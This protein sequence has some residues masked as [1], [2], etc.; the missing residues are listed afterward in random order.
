M[1]SLVIWK[2]EW[3]ISG[4]GSIAL[5]T[6]WPFIIRKKSYGQIRMTWFWSKKSEKNVQKRTVRFSA[7]LAA[8][9]I[10]NQKSPDFFKHGPDFFK[11]GPDFFKHGPDFFKLGPDFF[12]LGPDF[13][14]LGP[15]FFKLG[16]DFFKQ[17]VRIIFKPKVRILVPD[18][19][20]IL[21][22]S[23][24]KEKS[25]LVMVRKFEFFLRTPS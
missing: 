2:L 10:L 20:S 9:I 21:F 19:D 16:P 25:T 24:K 1:T 15:D 11:L 3:T 8:R 13:F 22:T 12:K 17:E 18:P 6:V 23:R 5:K 7:I 14:K 4:L